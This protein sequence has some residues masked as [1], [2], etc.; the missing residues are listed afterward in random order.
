[1]FN[2][3]DDKNKNQDLMKS[4]VYGLIP[5]SPTDGLM[6]SGKKNVMSQ[7]QIYTRDPSNGR[8][9]GP[10]V[11]INREKIGKFFRMETSDIIFESWMWNQRVNNMR[12]L[13]DVFKDCPGLDLNSYMRQGV[14]DGISKINKLQDQNIGGISVD[15][16]GEEDDDQT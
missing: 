4:P 13:Y 10:H 3:D 15:E 5:S 1:M 12:F 6:S 14:H 7:L 9:Q 11:G 2:D 8:I 16:Y